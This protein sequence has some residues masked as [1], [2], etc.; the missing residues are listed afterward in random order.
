[1]PKEELEK[2]K[3]LG[4]NPGPGGCRGRQQCDAFC[5]KPENQ[6]IC[7]QFAVENNLIPP[8]GIE[9]AKKI[10]SAMEQGGPGGC[11]NERECRAY[12]ENQENFETCGEFARKNNLM[13][14]QEIKMMER[15]REMAK[16]AREA[17]GPGG[18]AQIFRVKGRRAAPAARHDAADAPAIPTAI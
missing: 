13:G 2:A 12:C 14:E 1:M 11:K 9:R 4:N 8:E 3:R 5:G 16:K 10:K 18:W 17:G 6:E 15:G 7:F